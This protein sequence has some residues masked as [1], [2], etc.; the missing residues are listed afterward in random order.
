MKRLSL[1]IIVVLIGTIAFTGCKKEQGCTDA[2]ATNYSTIAE[3]DD[4]TCTYTGSV[5]FW[6]DATTSANLITDGATSLT[7]EVDGS[8]VGSY[9]TSVYFTS[10]PDC[11]TASIVKAE[12]DL[13]LVKTKDYTY[14]IK[15]DTGHEYFS[16]SVTFDATNSCLALELTL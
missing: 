14:S 5:V 6:Y 7:I 13:G 3:E 12:K 16:G 11:E 1:L 15:D 8:V 2:D 10:A 9:A 4:G